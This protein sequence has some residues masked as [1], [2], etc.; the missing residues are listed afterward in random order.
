M[1]GS[2][3]IG[4]SRWNQVSS[5]E[6]N[7][8]KMF[9]FGRRAIP[10]EVS[11]QAGASTGQCELVRAGYWI[12]K[13]FRA[14]VSQIIS[15]DQSLLS[16]RVSKPPRHKLELLFS[17][18]DLGSNLAGPARHCGELPRQHRRRAQQWDPRCTP[19]SRVFNH[20]IHAR[21]CHLG[22][23]VNARMIS[24]KSAYERM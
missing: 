4:I 17:G 13:R 6:L 18:I 16:E 11:R 9:P 12:T 19:S 22:A 5:G 20:L 10:P 14:S 8:E 3:Q 2:P 1:R 23:F 7:Q 15:L 24:G 21:S